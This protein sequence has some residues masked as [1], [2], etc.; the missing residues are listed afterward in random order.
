MM[1]YLNPL[2]FDGT[3]TVFG[4]KKKKKTVV[5]YNTFMFGT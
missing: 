5:R 2:T 4:T 3:E 1:N